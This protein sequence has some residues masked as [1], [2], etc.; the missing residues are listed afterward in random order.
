MKYYYYIPT[1]IYA[2]A[3]G[4]YFVGRVSNISDYSWLDVKKNEFDRNPEIHDINSYR[5]AVAKLKNLARVRRIRRE[6]LPNWFT[7]ANDY[8]FFYSSK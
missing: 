8:I 6:E 7:C 3:R 1:E 4:G 2:K 5:L